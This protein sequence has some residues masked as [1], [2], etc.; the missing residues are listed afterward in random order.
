MIYLTIFCILNLVAL[1]GFAGFFYERTIRDRRDIN[2]IA[3]RLRVLEDT[4]Q[5]VK[6]AYEYRISVIEH[7]VFDNRDTGFNV[8]HLIK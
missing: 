5:A 1:A 3:T 6:I 2:A 7:R 4:S 8:E